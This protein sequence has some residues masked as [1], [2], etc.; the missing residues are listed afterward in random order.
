MG[1]T[2]VV[3]GTLHFHH[4]G[5]QLKLSWIRCFILVLQYCFVATLQHIITVGTMVCVVKIS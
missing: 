1:L 4:G 3:V 2:V 5:V